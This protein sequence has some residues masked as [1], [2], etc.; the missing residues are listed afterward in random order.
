M[1]KSLKLCGALLLSTLLIS[2]GSSD[3]DTVKKYLPGTYTRELKKGE[4]VGFGYNKELIIKRLKGNEY[5]ISCQGNDKVFL[6]EVEVLTPDIFDFEISSIKLEQE[7]ASIKK[8]SIKG[9]VT[10]IVADGTTA[11]Y[12]RKGVNGTGGIT[13]IIGKNTVEALIWG[14]SFSSIRKK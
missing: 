12:A 13:L 9:F 1:R 10:N 7:S 5:R 14:D 2:C 11:S 4:M 3:E 8:Y 6:G